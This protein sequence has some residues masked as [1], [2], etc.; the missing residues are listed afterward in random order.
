MRRSYFFGLGMLIIYLMTTLRFLA[1]VVH[2]SLNYAYISRVLCVNRERPQ[3][4][5]YGQCHLQKNLEALQP[6]H[7]RGKEAM[8]HVLGSYHPTEDVPALSGLVPGPPAPAKASPGTVHTFNLL[9][10]ALP[11]LFHPPQLF[12]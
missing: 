3:L 9:N 7:N 12:A 5:C 11:T 1:P 4:Q 10:V 2:Y 6:A 8:Q